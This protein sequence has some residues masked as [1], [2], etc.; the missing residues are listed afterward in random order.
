MHGPHEV[1]GG[2]FTEKLDKRRDGHVRGAAGLGVG[3]LDLAAVGGQSQIFPALRGR[4]L[5]LLKDI[6]VVGD[7]Q[8]FGVQADGAVARNLRGV[9]GPGVQLRQAR[10]AVFLQQPRVGCLEVRVDRSTE[11]HVH[12][13]A[14]LLGHQLREGLAGRLVDDADLDVLRPFVN[15][16]RVAAPLGVHAAQDVELLCAGDGRE[17]KQQQSEGA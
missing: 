16:C 3:D 4:Q 5:F 7:A 1:K 13:G 8:H 17:G 15:R 12:L 14:I 9:L 6:G 10:R 2:F 11:P